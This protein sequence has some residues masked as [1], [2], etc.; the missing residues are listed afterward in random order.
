MRRMARGIAGLMVAAAFVVCPSAQAASFV[1]FIDFGAAGLGPGDT[2][3]VLVDD[4]GV[5]PAWLHNITDNI[6]GNAIGNITISDAKLTVSF[7]RTNASES[8]TLLGDTISLGTLPSTDI[9]IL[10]TDFPLNATALAALQLDGLFNVV[11]SESTT[12][13]DT[14]RMFQA[15]LSGNYTVNG[16]NGDPIPDPGPTSNGPVVPEPS[17]M[18]LL[19]PSLI[20]LAG[21]SRKKRSS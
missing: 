12:G 3:S 10:T 16:S 7:N 14:F 11:P 20:G 1:D 18:L 17:T 4:T 9:T 19:A 8:W 6:G 15:T 13:N 5:P 2:G 21:F